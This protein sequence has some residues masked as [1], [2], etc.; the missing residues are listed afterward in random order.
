MSSRYSKP[1]NLIQSFSYQQYSFHLL[2]L[3]VRTLREITQLIRPSREGPEKSWGSVKLPTG[4]SGFSEWVRPF[5]HR[6]A[7]RGR[8]GVTSNRL[9]KKHAE[10]SS[11]VSLSTCSPSHTQ[12]L[13]RWQINLKAER[14]GA[15]DPV[16]TTF[17]CKRKPRT[18]RLFPGRLGVR[19][20]A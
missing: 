14:L 1:C 16:C 11:S 18:H 19:A 4:E 17:S 12:A 9:E 8:W 13:P 20:E 5:S 2:Q 3:C 10:M 7:I 15:Q 6:W